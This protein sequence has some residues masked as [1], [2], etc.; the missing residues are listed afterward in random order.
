[1][2]ATPNVDARPSPQE[3]AA[4]RSAFWG[5]FAE[6]YLASTCF[7]RKDDVYQCA[8]DYLRYTALHSKDVDHAIAKSDFSFS[9][10]I[11]MVKKSLDV[12]DFTLAEKDLKKIQADL[13]EKFAAT[14]APAV[15]PDLARGASKYREHCLSCHGSVDGS[16]GS[17]ERRLKSRP[18]SLNAPWRKYSQTPL[19]IY[20]TL[21]HGVDGTE[22]LPLVEVMDI[23]ELWSIAFYV[24]TFSLDRGAPVPG[25]KFQDFLNAHADSFALVDLARLHDQGLIDRLHKLGYSC[26][27][28]SRELLYLRSKWLASAPRLGQYEKD[29]R[30]AKEAR[31]LTILIILITVTSLGFGVI[32]SRRSRFK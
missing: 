8:H 1:M 9:D 2:V 31:G 14:S 19:G 15:V 21:I 6:T 26:G 13:I 30:Q 25:E 32:L 12:R 17:L 18:Q 24:A 23:D 10:R 5:L 16:S 22:M 4:T 29:E 7:E 20:A 28:C 27:E 11:A 3:K